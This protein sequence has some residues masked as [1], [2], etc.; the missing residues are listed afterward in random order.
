MRSEAA[1]WRVAQSPRRPSR[2]FALGAPPRHRP[3]ATVTNCS[4]SSGHLYKIIIHPVSVLFPRIIPRPRQNALRPALPARYGKLFASVL[5]KAAN[6]IIDRPY[7]GETRRSER[8][9]RIFD[10]VRGILKTI[11]RTRGNEKSFEFQVYVYI[12]I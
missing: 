4:N 9:L 2:T 6:R 11:T 12:Y 3:R 10:F 8:A 7:A 1:P 5:C